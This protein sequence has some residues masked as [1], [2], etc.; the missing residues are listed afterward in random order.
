MALEG[1]GF[2]KG[3]LIALEG[4]WVGPEVWSHPVWSS[5]TFIIT[6]PQQG[7]V[8][9]VQSDGIVRE[10]HPSHPMSRTSYLVPLK[11]ISPY[12]PIM[13][14]QPETG[15]RDSHLL[16]KILLRRSEVSSPKG[17]CTLSH[18]WHNRCSSLGQRRPRYYRTYPPAGH[19]EPRR[20]L[21]RMTPWAGCSRM[22]SCPAPT[23][24]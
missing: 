19:F 18:L 7:N 6:L 21:S 2:G 15:S 1:A 14:S 24:L 22:Q 23:R 5:A 11:H 8:T 12:L 16:S 20:I 17:C 13:S 3:S 9:V 10:T 4:V